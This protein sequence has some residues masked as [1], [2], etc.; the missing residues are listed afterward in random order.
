MPSPSPR[1]R[2]PWPGDDPLYIAYHDEEWGVPVRDDRKLFAKLLLDGAQAGLSWITILRKRGGYYR[3]FDDF[4]PEKMAAYDEAKIEA[5]LQNPEIVRNR[6]KVNAFVKNARAY[7]RFR[8]DEGSFSDFLWSF[9]GGEPEVNAWE[10]MDPVPTETEAS[11][12]M[13]EALKERGF[14]FVGPT[15]CYAFMQAVGI[16]NDHLVSCFRHDQV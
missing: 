9:A 6:Q 8:E 1:T 7:L 10:T 11:R 16:V 15:I 3:A 2:C 5:L 14:S 12:A 13:S 4:D